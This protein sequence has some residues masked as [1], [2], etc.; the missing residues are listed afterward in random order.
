MI[1]L[2]APRLSRLALL[3]AM[4]ALSLL[5]AP[6]RAALPAE[7]MP[8]SEV[9]PGMVGEGR[10]VFQGY[11]VESFKATILGVEYN[12]F[13]GG[14]MILAKLEGPLLEQHGVVAGMSG[15][16]VFIDGKLIGAVAYGWSFAYHPY[17]GI[18]PI[19][20][21][22]TVWE[23]IGKPGLD[24]QLGAG[25]GASSGGRGSAAWDWERA[26][27]AY[28]AS[29]EPGNAEPDARAKASFR[30]NLPELKHLEGEMVPLS[31]PLFMS[32]ASPGTERLL[33]SFFGNRGIEVLSSGAM[34][35]SGGG[36]AAHGA[37]PPLSNGSAL[38]VPMLSGDLALAGV[39]T[40]TYTDG[41]KLIAFG[42]PMFFRGGSTAPMA[43]AYIFGFMQSYMR[44][45]KLSEVSDVIGT[46]DQDRLYAIG[47]KLG[48][49]PPRVPITVS[50]KGS[51]ASRPRDYHFSAWKH[52][53]FLPVMAMAAVQESFS[54]SASEGGRG[55][56]VVKYSIGL[57]D[58]RTIDKRRSVSDMSLPVA[59]PA[60]EMVFDLFML[61]DNIFG[62]ADVN[63]LNVEVDLTP[64]Y[65]GD[66]LIA[67]SSQY[68]VYEP[69][70]TA[71]L[72]LRFRPYQGPEY[73]KITRVPLP[74]TLRP[75]LYLLHLA[76]STSAA[77]VDR[78]HNA[79]LFAP[80]S[81]EDVVKLVDARDYSDDQLQ[82]Y[83]L[84]PTLD[85]AIDGQTLRDM[86][87][88][89]SGIVANTA[90]EQ[91]T[92]LAVGNTISRTTLTFPAPIQGT[93]SFVLE[94]KDHIQK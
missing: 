14:N 62:A 28:K 48:A 94:I 11:E 34:A 56:A 37:P 69:G 67:A 15:S 65:S 21:M 31:S 44:S 41:E 63:S 43:H 85:Y 26:W 9:K 12:A 60:L 81:L 30:S 47:G 80:R 18:S 54:A 29:L 19:E 76:D 92:D 57:A 16:P 79:A 84:E 38:G 45:F 6:A 51:A 24:E 93:A 20:N 4:F 33:R 22:W 2:S 7:F 23:N 36:T 61:T 53:D 82:V 52:P 77:R 87:Q 73:E 66:T 71:E 3:L 78:M 17:A 58:G 46:I 50:V 42:H 68:G 55:T 72:S 8:S 86:P 32:S 49:G 13:A 89:I 74:A 40:V 35:G 1:R 59:G 90:P 39:G 75:G 88:S 64:G 27:D 5:A 10:T 83:L 70:E 25:Y 91:L